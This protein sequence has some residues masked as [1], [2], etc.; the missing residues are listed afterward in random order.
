MNPVA[1]DAALARDA[2]GGAGALP[3]WADVGAGVQ[4]AV[5]AGQQTIASIEFWTGLSAMQ[6][7]GAIKRMLAQ[8]WSERWDGAG[9]RPAALRQLSD[10][11]AVSGWRATS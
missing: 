1:L 3:A 4:G 8:G 9:A 6:V 7:I 5:C 2:G 10:R 11:R